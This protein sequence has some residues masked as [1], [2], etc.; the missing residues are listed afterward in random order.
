M[1]NRIVVTL[2]IA[3]A[4]IL[5]GYA[6]GRVYLETSATEAG[7]YAA[8]SDQAIVS[9]TDEYTFWHTAGASTSWYRWYY[10]TSPNFSAYSDAFQV[11]DPPAGIVSVDSLKRRLGITDA[12]DDAYLAQV[13][14]SANA[15]YI[16]KIGMDLGPVAGT[17]I[18]TFDGTGERDLFIPAGIRSM[19]GTVEVTLDSG[20]SWVT[21]T[22]DLTL[23][24]RAWEKPP[25]AP[26][27]TLRIKDVPTVGVYAFPCGDDT[28]RI[29]GVDCFGYAAWPAD[30]VDAAETLGVRTFNGRTTGQRDVIGS[31]E[32][33]N[34]L[35]SRFVTLRDYQTA[36]KYRWSNSRFDYL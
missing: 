16:G 14:D 5:V 32:L 20:T 3:A 30:I 33:G 4:D 2:P 9:G 10:G 35:V 26:Y 15:W 28:V 22:A 8:V 12:T 21:V 29:T 19:P 23:R 11:T 27:H 1:S 17:A 31:D 6:A 24:P 36:D 34:P 25:N 7:S 13:A 18:R